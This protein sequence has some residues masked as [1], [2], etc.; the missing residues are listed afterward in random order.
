[1]QVQEA[2]SVL[3]KINPKRLTP[4]HILIKKTKA[5]REKKN[6]FK[7]PKIK[8]KNHIQGKFQSL[9]AEVSAETLQARW[10]GMDIFKVLRER[11]NKETNKKLE[12]SILYLER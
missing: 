5:K 11:M 1:M 7:C 6:S 3:S 2:Q 4:R 10:S 9:S 8:T 12:P